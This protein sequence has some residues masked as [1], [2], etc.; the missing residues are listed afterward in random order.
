[1]DWTSFQFH[2]PPLGVGVGERPMKLKYWV[3]FC[4]FRLKG[5]VC[6]GAEESPILH[7]RLLEQ[8][9]TIDDEEDKLKEIV[10]IVSFFSLLTVCDDF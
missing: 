3:L 6:E 4:H 7:L 2:S 5:L 1:M 8:L 9:E 10:A